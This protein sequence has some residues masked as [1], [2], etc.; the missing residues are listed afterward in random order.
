VRRTIRLQARPGSPLGWQSGII[1]SAC[2]R[3]VLSRHRMRISV[4][5]ALMVLLP[6]LTLAD[7]QWHKFGVSGSDKDNISIGRVSVTVQTREVHEAAFREDY[8]VMT[9][10]VPGQKPS[11]HWFTSSYGFGEVAVHGDVL[12]LKYGVG[13]GTFARVEHVR[14]LRF[15]DGLDE[16][17]DVQSSYYILTDPHNAAPD[18]FEY[19]VKVRAEAGYTTLSFSLPKRQRGIPSKKIVRLKN[20]S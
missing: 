19:R 6:M 8:L 18:L 11:E 17:A 9:V 4:S 1:A 13:R 2:L 3:Q 14:A 10:R 20:D 7:P 15:Q 5:I 12:L 16:L